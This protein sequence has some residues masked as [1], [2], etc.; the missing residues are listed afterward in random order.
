MAEVYINDRWIFTTSMPGPVSEGA[1][2]CWSERGEISL[3]GLR[4]SRGESLDE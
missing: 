1:F 2:G 4:I 3:E